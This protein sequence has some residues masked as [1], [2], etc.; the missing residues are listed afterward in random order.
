ML[1]TF[2]SILVLIL[3]GLGS[4]QRF[5][6]FYSSKFKVR[7]VWTT[8]GSFLNV[9]SANFFQPVLKIFRL[10]RKQFEVYPPLFRPSP[11]DCCRAWSNKYLSWRVFLH[12]ILIRC[13]RLIQAHN[14][15]HGDVR[16]SKMSKNKNKQKKVSN[17]TFSKFSD[18]IYV[19]QAICFKSVG[20]ITV[21]KKLCDFL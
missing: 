14:V 6:M 16:R 5:Q 1:T 15:R 8:A 18:H 17:W 9:F 7:R 13:I 3:L 4:V 10:V 21:A 2:A 11:L 12:Y 20:T 19:L